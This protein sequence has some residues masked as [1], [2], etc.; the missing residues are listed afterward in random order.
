MRLR[1]RHFLFKL[2]LAAFTAIPIVALSAQAQGQGQSTGTCFANCSGNHALA[3]EYTSA[4]YPADIQQLMQTLSG[5]YG[6]SLRHDAP[7]ADLAAQ[8]L[9]LETASI[10]FSL[11]MLDGIEQSGCQSRDPNDFEP[12][13]RACSSNDKLPGLPELAS[14]LSYAA[15]GLEK[16]QTSSATTAD[17]GG[18]E[19][20]LTMVHIGAM[21]HLYRLVF[22]VSGLY[23]DPSQNDAFLES[24]QEQLQL[25]RA[26]IESEGTL[27]GSNSQGDMILLQQ[28][29]QLSDRINSL[30]GTS[31]P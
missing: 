7:S 13:Q 14:S 27:C 15:Y 26:Y 12:D 20:C 4:E 28:L 25:A 17:R 22:S 24:A 8:D 31:L 29:S 23:L 9:N 19:L 5:A 3:T 30:R 18:S 11:W 10:Q 2:A 1:E 21:E 6:N 16:L